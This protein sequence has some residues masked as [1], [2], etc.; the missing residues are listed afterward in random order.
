MS[1][2]DNIGEKISYLKGLADGL[3]VG[4]DT[5]E[6]K[7]IKGILEVLADL[8]NYVQEVDDDLQ[9]TQEELLAIDEDLSLLEEDYY[10]A[11]D[12]DD[13]D[14]GCY[15]DDDDDMFEITCPK[16]G[17]GVFFD[18]ETLEADEDIYCPSCKEK[19]EIDISCDCDDCCHDH[20]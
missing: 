11:E 6:G 15:D 2:I 3:K 9:E 1:N 10:D 13:C 7:I 14:C 5:N 12:D 16:C 18:S 8:N 4:E 17:Q 20:E 19:I